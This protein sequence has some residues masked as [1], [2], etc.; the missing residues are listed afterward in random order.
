MNFSKFTVM[1]V[2]VVKHSTQGGP[3]RLPCTS[4]AVAQEVPFRLPD[5]EWTSYLTW[6]ALIFTSG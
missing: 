4:A 1:G 6:N 5:F 2:P 3:A